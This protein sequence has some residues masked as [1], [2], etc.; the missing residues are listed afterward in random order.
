MVKLYLVGTGAAE[1]IPVYGC[2]C[3][4]CSIARKDP[5]FRRKTTAILIVDS[6]GYAI[7]VDP[8]ID[9]VVQLIEDL[10]LELKAVL[11]THWHADHY[12]GL[13]K[14]RW[15]MKRIDVYAPREA[16]DE[17]LIENPKALK[18]HSVVHG[19]HIELDRDTHMECLELQHDIKTIGYLIRVEGA[20]IAIL[21]DTKLLPR[22]SLSLLD[23]H[24]IDVALIDATY[25]PGTPCTGHNNVDEAVKLAHRIKPK[26][27]FLVHI[28]H[29]NL[30]T[31]ELS[32]YIRKTSRDLNIEIPLDNTVHDVK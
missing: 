17:R 14:L 22:S 19:L 1:G 21:F 27:T 5:R 30:P 2:T 26:H 10:N 16:I 4:S 12:L 7:A 18:I 13:Y 15:S 32:D 3:R 6:S 9:S 8:S 11:I 28:A 29:H 23:K 25:A 31:D 20:N 24:S